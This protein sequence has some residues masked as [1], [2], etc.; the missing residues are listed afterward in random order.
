MAE[1]YNRIF[2]PQTLQ[3]LFTSWSNNKNAYI[4]APGINSLRF[5]G[6]GEPQAGIISLDKIAELKRIS[7]TERYLELGSMVR[8]NKILML[9]HAVPELLRRLIEVCDNITIRNI[10]TLYS[11]INSVGAAAESLSPP[12]SA[13]FL[14]V[15]AAMTALGAS[16]ELKTSGASRWVSAARYANRPQDGQDGEQ[17]VFV[18]VRVPLEKWDWTLCKHFPSYSPQKNE[19]GFA[20]F[21]ARVQNDTLSEL[22]VELSSA[23]LLRDINS[24]RSI[25]GKKLPL[26][27]EDIEAY[28][29]HWNETLTAA[30]LI[31]AF[32]KQRYLNFITESIS[33]FSE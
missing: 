3:D 24:E 19:E 14:A 31:S 13:V 5:E 2:S 4:Y 12:L 11:A 29:Q 16:Y 26:S 20:A 9:G 15:R 23:D 8:L 18:R 28:I 21:L 25:T 32:L 7:R 22:R 33:N 6:G 17:E 1:T 30:P 27:E 10:E